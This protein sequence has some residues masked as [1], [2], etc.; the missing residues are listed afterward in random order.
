MDGEYIDVDEVELP[1]EEIDEAAIYGEYA[2]LM[3]ELGEGRYPLDARP[4]LTE[5]YR[6]LEKGRIRMR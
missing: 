4:R 3:Q 6:A 2:E 1:E 5:I